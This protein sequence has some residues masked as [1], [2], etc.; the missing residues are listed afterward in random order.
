MFLALLARRILC[1][2]F[3]ADLLLAS[4]V[5]L[6]RFTSYSNARLLCVCHFHA[7]LLL[8]RLYVC[9]VPG[10]PRSG[11]HARRV[12]ARHYAWQ[13]DVG[14]NAVPALGGLCGLHPRAE[15]AIAMGRHRGGVFGAHL[16]DLAAFPY[17]VSGTLR[18]VVVAT[19]RGYPFPRARWVLWRSLQ[20]SLLLRQLPG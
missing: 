2:Y 6:A 18:F 20:G 11:S 19:R 12:G 8:A 5:A 13:S 15:L 10:K 14:V 17:S 1:S 7:L 3:G 16:G 9:G 4:L